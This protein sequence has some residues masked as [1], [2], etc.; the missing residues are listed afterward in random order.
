[1]AI[2]S[3]TYNLVEL[4]SEGS[5]FY[6]SLYSTDITGAE[7][8]IAAAAGKS[9]YIT[10]LQVRTATAMAITV[11]SGVTTGSVT[12]AHIGLVPMDAASGIFVWKAPPGKGLK[13]TSGLAAV[14]DSDTAGAIWIEAH[15]KTC[16]D[17]LRT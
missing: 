5:L 10:Y 17:K 13:C 11:G 4:P 3:N 12:T 8:I 9:H 7:S 6:E 16:K 2:T 15:G 1:M 14:I